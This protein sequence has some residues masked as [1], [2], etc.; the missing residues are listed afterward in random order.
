[1]ALRSGI[2][3]NSTGK[4]RFSQFEKDCA[5]IEQLIKANEEKM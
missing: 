2:V 3:E 5:K 4:R 1:M